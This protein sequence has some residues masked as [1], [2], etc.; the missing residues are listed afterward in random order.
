MTVKEAYEAW[1]KEPINKRFICRWGGFSFGCGYYGMDNCY[2]KNHPNVKY[3][4]EN[5]PEN[6][7][8]FYEVPSG[9]LYE[10]FLKYYNYFHDYFN[11]EYSIDKDD[12]DYIG[13]EN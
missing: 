13:E 2:N 10:D 9:I 5:C 6:C 4:F 12:T 3:G 8:D 11:K 1:K 7:K